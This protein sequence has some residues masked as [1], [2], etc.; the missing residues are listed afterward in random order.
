MVHVGM[1]TWIA[2]VGAACILGAGIGRM[3]IFAAINHNPWGEYVS[4]TGAANYRGLS[5]IFASWFVV[6]SLV[7]SLALAFL[8]W[9]LCGLRVLCRLLRAQ[10]SR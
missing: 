6:V 8:V 3:A 10:I 7:A 1:R 9:V 4:E 2:V 5:E